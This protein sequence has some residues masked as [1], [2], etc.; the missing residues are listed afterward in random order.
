MI[1]LKILIQSL[2]LA[3]V[4]KIITEHQILN[5]SWTNSEC[6]LFI[7]WAW[8]ELNHDM[9]CT[10]HL[11]L[12]QLHW[13]ARDLI[14]TR[15]SKLP[16]RYHET[17]DVVSI[18]LISLNSN[19]TCQCNKPGGRKTTRFRKWTK[20]CLHSHSR[21]NNLVAL[22]KL[23]RAVRNKFQRKMVWFWL[24]SSRTGHQEFWYLL[25]CSL[26]IGPRQRI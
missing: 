16:E 20:F 23:Q 9:F 13:E 2:R 12:T 21:S 10:T 25:Q 1:I 18:L 6:P 11:F 22:L 17:T 8:C 3:M 19:R 26:D 24:H 7:Q 14:H 4:I 15:S 5:K